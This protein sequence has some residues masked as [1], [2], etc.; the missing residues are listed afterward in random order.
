M[1]NLANQATFTATPTVHAPVS[2]AIRW[3]QL[4]ALTL[5][6]ASIAISWVAY[7][8][9][10]EPLLA[11]FGFEYL[12]RFVLV[13]QTVIL[14]VVPPLAGRLGD[15]YR[16]KGGNSLP[17]VMAGIGIVAM[18]FMSVATTIAIS[19]DGI[20]RW[21][22]PVLV[23][24]WLI[25]M[26]IFHAPALA[27]LEDMVS[28]EKMPVA[29]GLLTLV[30][31]LAYS[32]EPVIVPIAQ[33][34]GA[35]VTFAAGGILILLSGIL[36]RNEM[37]NVRTGSMQS[38][39]Q[40]KEISRSGFVMVFING[41]LLGI[42]MA[43]IQEILPNM[44]IVRQ[45]VIGG[46]QLAAAILAMA[47]ILAFFAGRIVVQLGWQNVFIPIACL[48]LLLIA[49]FWLPLPSWL[50]ALVLGAFVISMAFASVTALPSSFARL[51]PEHKALGIGLFLAGTELM[52]G[53]IR[54]GLF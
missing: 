38:S 54:L 37:R 43:F 15:R 8:N 17:V 16:A 32:L 44:E 36:Y 3:S 23:T 50:F 18:I 22:F 45:A 48:T 47:A 53:M 10:Q 29:V 9:F 12:G 21:L 2:P 19:P 30:T 34:I 26:N 24:L 51:R 33:A 20:F 31:D 14:L 28:A 35:P 6:S 13:A 27:G 5:L 7:H 39:R 52:A 49:A 42:C 46:E 25:A 40:I 11:Q 4:I 1:A 41:L